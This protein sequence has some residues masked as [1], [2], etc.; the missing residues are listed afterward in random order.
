MISSPRTLLLTI[1]C[2]LGAAS[3]HAQL[4]Q[5]DGYSVDIITTRDGLIQSQVRAIMEDS[6]GYLW[7]GTHRG[8]SRFDG[9]DFTNYEPEEVEGALG[10]NFVSAI[11]EDEN[12]YV[13]FATDQGVSYFDGRKF[14]NYNT[15]D[16]LQKVLSILEDRKGR[17]W[18]GTQYRGLTLYENGDYHHKP[19]RWND[20]APKRTVHA[21]LEDHT[22]RVWLGRDVG[23]FALEAD[24]TIYPQFEGILPSPLKIYCMLEDS[25][26]HMWLGTDQG[27]FFYDGKTFQQFDESDGIPDNTVFCMTA[28][29]EG[30]IWMGTSEGIA[31]VANGEVAPFRPQATDRQLDLQVQSAITDSEGN[32]WFGTEG[33]G[34]VRV[35]RS[36]FS[37]VDM[38]AGLGSQLAKSFL[39]TS[40]GDIWISTYDKGIGIYD[41]SRFVQHVTEADG[42]AGEDIGFSMID[43]QGN[44]WF[45][46][47]TKGLT[48][49]H[50]GQFQVFDEQSGL[51]SNH[52][53]CVGEGPAGQIWVGTDFGISILDGDQVGKH[54]TVDDGLIDNAIYQIKKNS[55]GEVWIG[56]PNGV[57]IFQDGTFTNHDTIGK[58]IIT[59]LEDEVGRMWIASSQ[60]L[61]HYNGEQF[62]TIRLD[63]RPSANNVVGMAFG[64][65]GFLWLGTEAGVYRMNLLVYHLSGKVVL[66]HFTRSDGLPSMETNANAIFSDAEGNIWVGTTDGAV[67]CPEGVQKLN[68]R[69]LP[70]TNIIEVRSSLGQDW[71]KLGFSV[72]RGTNLPQHLKIPFERNRIAFKFIGIDLENP[73]EVLYR[74]RLIG[75]EE[76]W[77]APSQT[78]DASYSNLSPKTYTFEVKAAN[79]AENWEIPSTTFTFQ[80][81]PAFWQTSVFQVL[82]ALLLLSIGVIIYKVLNAR[83][84]RRRE[85]EQMKF[86]A[87]K[88]ALEHQ[89]LYAM[90]NPHFTFNALQ[91]IQYFI[92]RQDKIS[93]NKFLSRFAK[94]IR[95]NLES[96]K[97]EFI[98]LHEEVSRLDLYLS[99]EMMRFKDKFTYEVVVDASVDQHETKVPPMIFQPYVENS[100]KHGIN[101]LDAGGLIRVH[102]SKRDE[103][104]LLITIADNGIGISASKKRRADRPQ[105]HV[106]RGMQITHDR[107]ALFAK[108]TGKQY[109][110]RT[111]E[112]R[113]PDGSVAGTEVTMLLPLHE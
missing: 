103:D 46:S 24:G 90:M 43:S 86:K 36:L 80:I 59:F 17:L 109:D 42:L 113:H 1:C 39:Q 7:F 110:V 112:L 9:R 11:L 57:S 82:M 30:T 64:R 38:Q 18:F 47:Y 29:R 32:L 83:T 8:L 16:S 63:Q 49:Y 53:F 75:Y 10:G 6:R 19:F 87:E 5:T 99:L 52:T 50:N 14:T 94:L 23:L 96:S 21:I 60:G 85:E 89:A 70:R 56:T 104:Y 98:S 72:E 106:S 91:S 13:W 48:K 105:D 22:G 73:A 4:S 2:L 97:S 34:V 74:Y 15:V 58:N 71:D 33:G 95:Q 77:S 76:A 67:Y 40:D 69:T 20:D 100:I 111:E 3:L 37:T 88:L 25:S 78:T 92:L 28:D 27:A 12:G 65:D 62:T 108:M 84:K 41:G 44:F 81:S 79:D 107:L 68:S 55:K 101:P 61:I 26:H 45:T 31:R 66:E 35:T 93:A 54:Y 51:A 102:I